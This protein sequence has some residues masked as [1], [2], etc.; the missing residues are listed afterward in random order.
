MEVFVYLFLRVGNYYLYFVFFWYLKQSGIEEMD[1]YIFL[2]IGL[3]YCW[4]EKDGERES[5]DSINLF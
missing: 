1:F 5:L 3:S 2:V 4:R